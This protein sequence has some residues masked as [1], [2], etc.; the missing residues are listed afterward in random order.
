MYLGKSFRLTVARAVAVTQM[1][2]LNPPV[3][4]N[5]PRGREY[6]LPVPQCRQSVGRVVFMNNA[7]TLQRLFLLRSPWHKDT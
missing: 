1:A 5:L 2:A 3:I 4:Q 7:D 6:L